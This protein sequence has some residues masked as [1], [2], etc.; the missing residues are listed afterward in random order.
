LSFIVQK[1]DKVSIVL[2]SDINK[3]LSVDF[4]TVYNQK[5]YLPLLK[6]VLS[7]NNLFL[8]FENGV[9]YVSNT[10]SDQKSDKEGELLPPPP[11]NGS[12]ALAVPLDHNVTSF[13]FDLVPYTLKYLQVDNIRPILD[14]SGISYSFASVSKTIFFKQTKDNKKFIAKLIKQL[15][16]IDVPKDQVTLKITIFDSN[17]QKIKEVGINSALKFDFDLL[18]QT[19]ALITGSHVADFKGS[20]KLLSSLGAT[21][22]QTST[23]YLV[24]DS[25]KLDFKKIVSLPFLDENYVV[26]NVTG[27]TNQSKKYKYKDIGFTVSCTPTIVN[28]SVYLDFDLTVGN[29]VSAGDLPVTSQNAISNKF[30]LHRGD[31]VLLAGISKDSLIDGKDSL[32]FI[33]TIPFLS[34]IFTHKSTDNKKEFFNV[35]IEIN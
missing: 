3:A 14:F 2:G 20:L 34:D 16:Y 32:P 21:T 22:I 6:S 24:S 12:V 18:S 25:D 29:V 30:S 11:L 15:D 23:S 31:V 9:Y 4:P 35:S 10:P 26:S 8:R 33:D 27:S 28:D 17:S 13:D 1:H 19:G 5:D 7:S